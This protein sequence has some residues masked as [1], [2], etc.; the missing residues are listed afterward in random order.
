ML[1]KI[2][3]K[4]DCKNC[5]FCCRFKRTSLWET[6]LFSI[7]EKNLVQKKFPYAKF[8]SI[9]NDSFTIDLDNSYNTSNPDE[10]A[11]CYFLNEAQGCI[12]GKKEK[13][14]DCSIWPLRLMKKDSSLVIALT[15]TCTVI[16]SI[17][18][19]NLKQF[20]LENL[21]QEIFSQGETNPY[22][23]KHYRQ[24]FP[25]ILTKDEFNLKK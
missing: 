24:A 19:E 25:I 23:I 12:L 7:E 20:V 13:P 17:P 16:N 2:L 4:N 15:P 18:I 1:S 10:E 14:F 9:S 3:S 8:K 21:A 11:P 6:P 5:K 22:I